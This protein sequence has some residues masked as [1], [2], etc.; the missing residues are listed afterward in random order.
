MIKSVEDSETKAEKIIPRPFQRPS[1]HLTSILP[2]LPTC[3]GP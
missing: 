2:T 1:A 3:L